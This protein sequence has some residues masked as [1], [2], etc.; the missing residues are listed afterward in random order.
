MLMK[1]LEY[2]IKYA[3]NSTLYNSVRETNMCIEFHSFNY[4]YKQHYLD[5]QNY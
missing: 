5:I 4:P 2:S 3:Y 1:R